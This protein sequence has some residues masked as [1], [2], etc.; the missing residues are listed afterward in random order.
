MTWVAVSS[1]NLQAVSY[2]LQTQTLSIRFHH[3]GVYHY[4]GVPSTVYEGLMA[5][6]S[7]GQYFIAHIKDRY[8]FTRG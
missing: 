4:R 8:P 5:A 7:K 3:G 6:G 2:S 1:S